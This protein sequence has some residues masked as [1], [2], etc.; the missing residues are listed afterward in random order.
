MKPI[1]LLSR[2]SRMARRLNAEQKAI[3][4]QLKTGPKITLGLRQ[5]FPSIA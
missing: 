3:F 2:D 4:D 1:G 5:R